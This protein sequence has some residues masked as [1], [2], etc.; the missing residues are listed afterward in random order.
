MNKSLRRMRI[1]GILALGAMTILLWQF[2]LSPRFIEPQTIQAQVTAT[3]N[4]KAQLDEE[5]AVLINR[6][7]LLEAAI[8]E[9]NLLNVLMPSTASEP[10]LA[11]AIVE[12]ASKA[13]MSSGQ[14]TVITT[15]SLSEVVDPNAAAAPTADPAAPPADPAA[16][17]ADPNNITVDTS[18]QQTA[19]SL[20]LYQM[21][22][23]IQAVG[24]STQLIAFTN[25]LY[26]AKRA[27]AVDHVTL[28]PDMN[29]SGSTTGL[30][31]LSL[32]GRAFVVQS[33]GNP[34]AQVEDTPKVTGEGANKE[35]NSSSTP[36][37]TVSPTKK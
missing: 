9:A 23:S 14:I 30:Y 28:T 35:T 4:E 7:R 22:V 11:S 16:P 13:G 3:L 10:E 2:I 24:T 26:N 17:P 21:N 19:K 34:P 8:N 15:S 25:G 6:S 5:G 36:K 33:I 1:F 20:V 18:T 29:Q 12:I 37:P 31:S 27:I 32:E